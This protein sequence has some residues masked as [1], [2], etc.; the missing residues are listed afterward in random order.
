MTYYQIRVDKPEDFVKHIGSPIV[1]NIEA[2]SLTEEEKV[3]LER[4]FTFAVKQVAEKFNWKS[5]E[6]LNN[7]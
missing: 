4:A 6:D 2:E 7:E 5:W 1:L 3:T